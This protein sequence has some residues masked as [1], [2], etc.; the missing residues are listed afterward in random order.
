MTTTFP[1]TQLHTTC[2][3]AQLTPST[4]HTYTPC[5]TPHNYHLP[6][7]RTRTHHTTCTHTHAHTHHTSHRTMQ[8][9]HTSH[10]SHQVSISICDTILLSTSCSNADNFTLECRT[11]KVGIPYLSISTSSLWLSLSAMR[12]FP[13]STSTHRRRFL[14]RRCSSTHPQQVTRGCGFPGRPS[15]ESSTSDLGAS[16]P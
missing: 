14:L 13:A 11:K 9:P 7:T 12:G 8:T 5:A 6:H 10:M 2:H 4:T 1:N 15:W 16:E 3:T